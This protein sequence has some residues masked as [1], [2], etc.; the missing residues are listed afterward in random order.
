PAPPQI[1]ILPILPA[2]PFEAE[3][4]S[5]APVS[6]LTLESGLSSKTENGDA[7]RPLLGRR[8]IV[9]RAAKQSGDM[10]RAL[11]ALGAE[12]ISCPTIEIKEPS[13]WEQ[14]DQDRKS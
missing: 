10:T 9:T 4:A 7:T 3:N 2:K 12:V 14:L 5:A 1:E 11:E 6:A 13:S 8:V